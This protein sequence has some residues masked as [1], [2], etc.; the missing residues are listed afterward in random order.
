M[1]A[2]LARLKAHFVNWREWELNPVVIKELRQ[3]VRSWAVTGMLLLFLIVLF[4]TSLVFLVN[5]TFE[6]TANE[7]LGGDIFQAFMVILAGASILF[8]PLYVGIRMA[9]E[10]QEGNADLLYISTL[11]PARVIRGKFFCG[12]YMTLLFFSACMPFMAF[13]NLLRGVDLPSVFFILAFL[14]VV[15]CAANQLAIFIA[16]LPVSRPFKILFALGG[17]FLAYWIVAGVVFGAI[18]LM[19]SGIGSMMGERTFW[20]TTLTVA[21]VV[22]AIGGLLFVL[23]VAL[24]SP[25]SANRAPLL[26][27]YITGLWL[28]GGLLAGGWAWSVKEPTIIFVWTYAGTVL[29]VASLIVTVSNHDQLSVRVRRTIPVPGLKR[30]L[31][32]LFFNGA[33]GGLVW[34][35]ALIALTF[36]GTT[37]FHTMAT[38]YAGSR[39][40][41]PANFY[42]AFVEVYPPVLVYIFAYALTGLFIQRKFLPR[43]SPKFAGL[44]T[45]LVAALAAVGPSIVLF[46]MNRLSWKTIE[47]LQLGSASNLFIIRDS[48]PRMAHLLFA[49]GWLAVALLLNARWFLT[50]ARNFRPPPANEPPRLD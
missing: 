22:S 31:A 41:V 21:G 15:I 19:R 8:I 43:H 27:I 23:S 45:L 1:T 39:G 35:M 42:S 48:E 38:A 28:L 16:C 20:L 12:A 40:F 7:R 37:G 32:F 2:T 5:Q 49:T 4:V 18:S 17:L 24:I 46:F 29:L 30:L 50:Q 14:F 13:T 44:L 34:V 11:S 10:R 6:V 47:K 36:F 26:R 33:A 3:A 9:S 25:P